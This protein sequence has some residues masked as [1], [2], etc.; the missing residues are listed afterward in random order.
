MCLRNDAQLFWSSISGEA[1]EEIS[2][3]PIC[4][5]VVGH[6]VNN[7]TAA[8]N[9]RSKCDLEKFV[10]HNARCKSLLSLIA[11]V[12]LPIACS[13]G[14][15][16]PE[17]RGRLAYEQTNT[18]TSSSSAEDINRQ[19]TALAS[20]QSSTS[21]SEYQIGPEDLLEITLF[22]I[23]TGPTVNEM[24]LT[25]R[26]VT[27]RVNHKGQISLPLL[28]VMSIKGLT[29]SEFEQKLRGGYERY[30]HNPEVG[31][32]VKEFRQR[33]SVVG[34]VQKPGFIELTG[35]K[36]V[37]EVLALAGGIT[38]KAG[39]RVHISHQGPEGRETRVIDLL[40]LPN[41]ASLITANGAGLLSTPVQPG[42]VI[43]VPLAGMF[44]VDGAVVRPGSYPLG[45]HYSLTQAL[46]VAGGVNPDLYSADITIFRRKTS[47]GIEPITVDLK[48]ILASSA[49]DPKIE[50]DDVILVPINGFKYAFFR[51]FGQILGW[52]NSISGITTAS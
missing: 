22:N 28:G 13:S 10:A 4:S 39:T 21:S 35:P 52:G 30:F 24:L 14:P 27:V 17:V 45:R 43:D 6:F 37:I 16:T 36:T 29:I 2:T 32:L 49:T 50:E 42:D 5:S 11:V 44:Y 51:V 23:I 18:A 8:D 9:C 47:S 41:N 12:M 26:V 25:P 38:D 40:A 46:A 33:V 3:D 48:T 7:E 20:M 19:I 31:V 34:A 1:R 15:Q